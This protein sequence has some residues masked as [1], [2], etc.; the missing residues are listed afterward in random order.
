MAHLFVVVVVVLYYVGENGGRNGREKK[1]EC[2]NIKYIKQE[3]YKHESEY[4]LPLHIFNGCFKERPIHLH[5]GLSLRWSVL[6]GPE[7]RLV[8]KKK[9]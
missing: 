9:P 1:K 7:N 2:V 6:V 8:V 4:T 5:T 3:K